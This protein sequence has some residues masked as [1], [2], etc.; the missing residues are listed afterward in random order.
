M[1]K[2]PSS[3]ETVTYRT[4]SFVASLRV[5][6]SAADRAICRRHPIS[7]RRALSTQVR[8][9]FGQN[10]GTQFGTHFG[11]QFRIPRLSKK[12]FSFPKNGSNPEGKAEREAACGKCVHAS[13]AGGLSL[14]GSAPFCQQPGCPD[15]GGTCRRIEE[16]N[17][18]ARRGTR[19][20]ARPGGVAAPEASQALAG[21]AAKHPAHSQATGIGVQPAERDF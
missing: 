12:Y 11:S 17:R 10:V 13:K 18:S 4:A 16:R 21:M 6:A 5:R 14:S 19:H 20:S 7:G 3:C 9:K 15:S 1:G 2:A 8:A